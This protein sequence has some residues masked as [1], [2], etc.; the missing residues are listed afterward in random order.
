MIYNNILETIGNTPIVRLNRMGPDHVELYVKVESFNPM[1]SVKDRLAF[2]IINDAEQ[3]GTLEPGQTVVEATSGNTGIALAMVCAATG[4]PF[5][6]TMADSFS[7]ER[8]MV[9]RG[10]GAKVILT[11]AAERGTGMV[12]KAEELAKKHGWF[13]ARQFENPANPDYHAS[14]TGPEILS[15]FS[16][17]RL[18]YWVTGYGTGGTMSG[19]GRTIKAARPEIKIVATEPAGAA[20]LAGAE[21]APH[22]IQGWTPD[23]IPAVL[24][25]EVFDELRSISDDRAIEVS[26]EL[27]HKEGIFTGISAGATLATAL[28]VAEEAP[29]GSVI[30]AMLPDTG[31]RYLSTPLFEGVPEGSDDEWL[32]SQ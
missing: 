6:A 2:A 19:A 1:A 17:R 18:D 10:L 16:G 27:S 11:P 23:F 12:R 21:W 13:L 29:E 5:V 25:R 31:E 15:D 7:V 24:D 4:H 9:M 14:T 32:A 30:L 22:K 26:R 8:R 20:L 28:D 3:K